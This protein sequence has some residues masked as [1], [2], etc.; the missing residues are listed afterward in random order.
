MVE[1]LISQ[2]TSRNSD[3]TLA[4]R[5]FFYQRTRNCVVALDGHDGQA[6]FCPQTG[7]FIGSSEGPKFFSRAYCPLV[8]NWWE[9]TRKLGPEVQHVGLDGK[10]Q[11]AGMVT[12]ADDVGSIRIVPNGTAAEAAAIIRHDNEAFNRILVEGN[13]Q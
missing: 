11:E 4:H 3:Y 2:D 7:N 12:F 8:G 6:C 1:E 9:E 13:W 10:L 5:D